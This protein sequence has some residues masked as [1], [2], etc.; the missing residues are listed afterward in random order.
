M[1]S[2][3]SSIG[4]I[5]EL[6]T[7]VDSQAPPQTPYIR[8]SGVGSRN[9]CF[10]KPSRGFCHMAKLKCS[11]VYTLTIVS[12]LANTYFSQKGSQVRVHMFQGP[13]PGIP[14][15]I[16]GPQ[17]VPSPHSQPTQHSPHPLSNNTYFLLSLVCR[18]LDQVIVGS[19]AGLPFTWR[20][21]YVSCFVYQS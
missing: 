7:N 6:V 4:F 18:C 20:S 17:G 19:W 21:I 11:W 15:A 10:N 2:L 16:A 3:T 13:P 14:M 12:F 1:W 8:H 5:W 9:L